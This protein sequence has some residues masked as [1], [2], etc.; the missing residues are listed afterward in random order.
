MNGLLDTAALHLRAA[1]TDLADD[2]AKAR[3]ERAKR[4]IAAIE[5]YTDEYGLCNA[6]GVLANYAEE[7]EMDAPEGSEAAR[8]YTL[9]RQVLDGALH[10]VDLAYSSDF[11]HEHQRARTEAVEAIIELAQEIVP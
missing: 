10:G 7:K 11:P 6:V 5:E 9:A 8:D 1:T 3:Q 2:N 4:L